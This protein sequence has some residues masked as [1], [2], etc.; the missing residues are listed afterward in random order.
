MQPSEIRFRV[1]YAETDGMGVVHHSRYL[2]WLEMG[3][4]EFIRE[5]GYTYRQMEQAG[6]LLTVIEVQIRYKA[7]AAYDDTILL[8]T[9]LAEMGRVKLRFAYQ[10]YN[11]QTGRLLAEAETTHAFVGRDGVP[12]RVMSRF[13]EVW[14]RLQAVV[15]AAS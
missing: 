5:H 7:P 6:V 13:P 11:E 8:H 10:V 3:R 12:I 2:P 9:R 1:R 4:T 14:E 15:S